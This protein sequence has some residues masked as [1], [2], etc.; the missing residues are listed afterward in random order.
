[1]GTL[2]QRPRWTAGRRT[3]HHPAAM[4]DR[5][6]TPNVQHRPARRLTA[7]SVDWCSASVWSAPDGS[8]LLTLGASSVQTAPEGSCRIVWMIKRMIKPC[9]AA[10]SATQTT[11][12]TV[13]RAPDI[14]LVTPWRDGHAS[15]R[16]KCHHRPHPECHEEG[17]P[18]W[19]SPGCHRRAHHQEADGNVA[20]RVGSVTPPAGCALARCPGSTIQITTAPPDADGLRGL[21]RQTTAT[22]SRCGRRSSR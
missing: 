2:Q 11:A 5:N 19:Q 20:R 12:T 9:G 4:S 3:V 10:P 21:A 22:D 8:N 7:R 15:S 1:M 16:A 6:G 17:P 13:E 18:R 14:H